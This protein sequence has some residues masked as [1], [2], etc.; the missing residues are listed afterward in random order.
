M[1]WIVE[2][3]KSQKELAD[4]FRQLMKEEAILQI[5]GAHDAM[6]ALVAKK[7]G[8]SALYLSGGAYTASRGLPDLGIVTSTEVAD[9]AKDLVRATNLP[10]LV[11]IDTGFGGVLNVARTAQEML[12]ANVAA[13][14]IEDQQLPKKCG[15][16]N[17]KQLV[18]K[19]EMEQK[20]QAI[21]KVA[22]TLVIVARTD[23]RANEGLNGAIER[24]NVYIEAGAD[25]IFPEALQSAEEFRLVAENVSAPLLA[26]MTEFGKTP[27][28]TA[29]GLQNAGF[30]MVIYPVTSLRVAAKAYERI[31]QLIKDEGTQEAGI[32]D[33]QTRKE[34]YETI[35]Y[36][37]F[38]ALDKNIAK[39]VLGE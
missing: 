19:E 33:M 15:H 3:P 8:F 25:A 39:T 32:E 31:F 4:R 23:A 12:E 9:R 14:Q 17:G 22:P 7:A 28:M 10:V 36:D 34:L 2:Q 20:I 6:A 21:K 11:D 26:N 24:A 27:L 13:V 37:D 29:G 1:A 38:E 35:S 5:P 16:L 18:S 30:Q